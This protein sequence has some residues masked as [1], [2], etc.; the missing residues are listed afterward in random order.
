M[1]LSSIEWHSTIILKV[2]T[3]SLFNFSDGLS[4]VAMVSYLFLI[5][6][7]NLYKYLDGFEQYSM[8]SNFPNTISYFIT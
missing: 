8:T 1:Y 4:S 2:L 7:I 6:N 3:K 5:S